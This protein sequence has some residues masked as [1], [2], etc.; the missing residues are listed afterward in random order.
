VVD[1]AQH[2]VGRAGRQSAGAAAADG[3]LRQPRGEELA[4]QTVGG[5]HGQ[6]HAVEHREADRA[7]VD[8]GER[9]AG[10]GG[11]S[12]FVVEEQSVA[13]GGC[14]QPAE[15]Q[16]VVPGGVVE[17]R[18]ELVAEQVREVQVH[19][20]SARALLQHGLHLAGAHLELAPR[21]GDPQEASLG[22][23]L[24][25]LGQLGAAVVDQENP[26][27]RVHLNPGG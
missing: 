5:M 10:G 23:R 15:H 22:Q 11:G 26:H 16:Q 3:H 9:L 27:G 21:R 24:R 6:Q 25:Q 17:V 14:G 18:G 12:V 7:G 20:L 4:H 13:A 1:D 2:E 19:E 8:R